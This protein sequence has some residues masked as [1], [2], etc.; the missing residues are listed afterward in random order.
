MPSLSTFLHYR[1]KAHSFAA[2]KQDAPY[3]F[4]AEQPGFSHCD[5]ALRTV[6]C[7]KHCLSAALW[8]VWALYGETVFEDLVDTTFDLARDLHRILTESPDFEPLHA[9]EA[10]I[11]CFRHL[12]GPVR[13]ARSET[14]SRFQQKIRRKLVEEGDP[15]ITIARIDGVMALR[16]T[17]MNPFTTTSHLDGLLARIRELGRDCLPN[18]G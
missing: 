7:T 15:Y 3:L 14:V 18:A 10:N 8:G 5:G 16:V 11:L 1:N 6:E 4:D 13:A 17:L 2:F 12:P 9:P